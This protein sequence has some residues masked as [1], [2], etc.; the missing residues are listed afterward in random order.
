MPARTDVIDADEAGHWTFTGYVDENGTPVTDSQVT[1]N[2]N[3]TLTGLWKHEFYQVQ[4]SYAFR[5]ATS[6]KLPDE[7]LAAKP[8]DQTVDMS[9]NVTLVLPEQQAWP[10]EAGSFQIQTRIH[11]RGTEEAGNTEALASSATER[12]GA[13]EANAKVLDTI[14]AE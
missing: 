4:V 1:L 13:K 2:T 8:E 12:T 5:S 3:M 7:I 9:S 6:R 14:C 11:S 10:V